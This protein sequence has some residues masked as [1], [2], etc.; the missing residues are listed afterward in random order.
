MTKMLSHAAR[1]GL[2]SCS[3]SQGYREKIYTGTDFA[4]PLNRGCHLTAPS[5]C[6]VDAPRLN[7][8]QKKEFRNGR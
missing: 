4:S 5:S 3:F 8:A 1:C 7:L 2:R 6:T